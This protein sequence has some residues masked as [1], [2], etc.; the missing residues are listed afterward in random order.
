MRER[1]LAHCDQLNADDDVDPRQYFKAGSRHRKDDYKTRRLC[2]QVA[3]TLGLVLAGECR[4]ERLQG[5]RVVSVDPA[6]DASQLS[7]ALRTDEPCT[8]IA[9]KEILDCLATVRGFLRS[10]VAAAISR[11]RT[12]H[13]LFR[14]IGPIDGGAALPLASCHSEQTCARGLPNRCRVRLRG[15]SSDLPRR[16]AYGAWWS[17]P[18]STWQMAYASAR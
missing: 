4:D 18:T 16:T 15:Q 2:S 12:P 7:V 3:D 11:K 5:L 9:H 6:P 8:D 1:L 17:C 10:A 13:L 14:V